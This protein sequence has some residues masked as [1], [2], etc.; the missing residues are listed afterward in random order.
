VESYTQTYDH[1]NWEAAPDLTKATQESGLQSY[2]KSIVCI[3]RKLGSRKFRL[4][5][6][7]YD[8]PGRQPSY[9][10]QWQSNI[11]KHS[12][13]QKHKVDVVSP[14]GEER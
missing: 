7:L 11:H 4:D 1:E 10:Q 12:R 6:E 3:Y 9:G 5:R 14:D 8:L 13:R 2:N